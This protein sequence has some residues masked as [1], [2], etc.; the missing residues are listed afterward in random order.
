MNALRAN[1]RTLRADL[2]ARASSVRMIAV[3]KADAY[4]HGAPACV[5]ALLR[6]G[7]DFFAVSCIEEAI[8]VRRVCEEFGRD[9]DILILGYTAPE[10]IPELLRYRLTQTLLSETYALAL[11]R[12]AESF[13]RGLQVHAAINTGMNR[14]GFQART[15]AETEE[16]AAAL[17]R[18]SKAGVLELSGMF[19]HFAKADEADEDGL[20][21]TEMQNA[22][23]RNLCAALE[24]RGCRIPFHHV[25]NSAA[26]V[27]GIGMLLDGVRL[28]ISLYGGQ[29]N[30]SATLPLLPV[31]RLK[32]EIVHLYDLLPG[33]RLGYGGAFCS[34]TARRIAV[35]PI[36]YADGFLRAYSGA[37]VT[38][39]TKTG[40]FS[41]PIVG[42]ICMDQCMLDVTGTD[43]EIGDCVTLFGDGSEQLTRLAEL[44]NTI[45]YESLCLVSARV[46]RVYFGAD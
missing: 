35:L 40:N 30:F 1:Y 34:D 41:V 42:R 7:C 16:T 39:T 3:V 18:I 45:D 10:S 29:P 6:E 26:A 28:G 15:P 38:L 8:P 44:G 24:A 37:A 4:G 43:A 36:G 46:P 33:E 9:A 17:D 31:M 22:R 20:S 19:T 32:A 12:F 14:I 11:Q 21:Y 23:Y 5:R 27:R 25:C 13:G 2:Q